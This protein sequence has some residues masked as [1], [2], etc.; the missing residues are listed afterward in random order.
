MRK[1]INLLISLFFLSI[2]N[3]GIAQTVT[4]SGDAESFTTE[5]RQYM[6]PN[7]NESETALLNKFISTWDSTM[8]D[9]SLKPM[10]MAGCI[11]M[12]NKRMRPDP[13]FIE[14]IGTIMD[15]IDYD[16]YMEDFKAWLEGLESLI[17]ENR[18]S[19][20]NIRSFINSATYLIR[21]NIIYHSSSVIW[22]TTS[23]RFSFNKEPSFTVS[24]PE[25]DIICYASRDSTIIHGT[26]GYF[27]PVKATWKGKGGTIDWSKAGYQPGE[28]YAE[29]GQYT[30]DLSSATFSIDSVLFHNS[31]YFKEPVYGKL[32]DRSTQI[33]EAG[34]ARFPKFE[35]YQKTFFLEDI[36]NEIDF[37]GG[38]T[39][40]G[41]IVKGTGERY[42][43]AIITMYKN[44]TLIA[45]ARSQDFLFSQDKIQTQ[46]T[47]FTLYL[48]ED[49]IY[50]SD[51]AFNF[52]VSDRE[53]N[54]YR[55]R[56]PTSRSP[57]F[58]SYHM[59]DM[60]FDYLSWK[61]DESYITLSRARGASRG[62]AYFESVSYFNE[63]EFIKMMGI[64]DYHPLYRLRAFA[65]YYY[66]KT[67]PVDE[68]ARWMNK[69]REYVIAMC[70]D[71][72]N[73]GF[74]FYDRA[75]NEV[76]IKQKLYD[77][78]DFYRK[79]LDY[80]VMSIFSETSSPVDNATLNMRN[81]KM[82]IKGVPRVFL[83]DSQNVRIFPYGREITLERN[84][85]FEFNGVV[86]AGMITVF[87]HNFKFS[88]DT[89]KINLAKVDSIM[90][91]VETGEVD[92][93]GRAL[94]R[95]VED[96]IQMTKADLLIDDPRNKSGLASLEQYPIFNAYSE[97][98]VFYDKIPNLEGVYPQ[99]D[100]YFRLIP[101]TFENTDRLS[102]SDLDLKGTFY[103]GKIIEPLDQTLTLQHDNSLGFFYKIPPEGLDVYKGQGTLYNSIE[104]S[105]RG[106]IGNGTLSYLTTTAES[107]KFRFFPDSMLAKTRKLTVTASTIFPEVISEETNI[108]WYPEKDEFSIEPLKDMEFNMFNN[109]TRL[110]GKLLMKKNGLRGDGV[111]NLTDSYLEANNYSF[112]PSSIY[113]D[114]ATYNLKSVSGDGFA[115]IADDAK[116]TIDFDKQM[117]VFSLNTDSSMVK[118]P[119]VQY[120]C[121]MT[122]FEYDMADKVLKMK[123]EGR[124]ASEL[125]SPEELLKQDRSNLEEPTFFSTNKINDTLTFSA[126]SGEYSLT[127]E[128]IIINNLNYI[129]VA[130]ALIQPDMGTL[131]I[132][133]G[134]KTD[135]IRNATIAINNT[136]LI[137][138]ASIDIINSK[139]Y[140]A[141]G[142]Y[143]YVDET[144]KIQNIKFDDIRV[145]SLRSKGS[146]NIPQIDNFMLSPEFTFQGD[147]SFTN[148]R[149]E[150]YF[151]G[152]TGIVQECDKI[153]SSPMRFESHIDPENIM[154]P[155]KEKPRDINGNLITVGSYIAVDS[156][157]IY[158]AFLS[159]SKSWADTPLVE[160]RGFI[161]YD[162]EDGKYKVAEKE[163]LANT[164]LPGS[165][166]SFDRNSC[167][168]YSEGPLNLGVDYGHL[169]IS[170]A[171]EV[172]HNTDS[173]IV[174]IDM[175]LSLDF[176]FSAPA[177]QVMADEIRYIPTLEPV[178]I[179][180][181]NYT[182]S[183][184][185][186]LGSEAAATLKEEMDLF[187]VSRSLPEGFEPEI[188]LN[189]LSLE[190]NQEFQ[191][192]RSTGKIGIGFVGTQAMNVY[193]D[194]YVELQKRRSG[195]LLDVYLK[196]DDA[197]WY[198]FSY[199][200]GVLMALSGNN[201]FNK[202]LVE[203]KVKD[204]RHPDHSIRSPYTYMVGVRT[205]MENFLRRM[206]NIEDD[207][208]GIVEEPI[209]YMP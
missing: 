89:F 71:L 148:D 72:T 108:K 129:P 56:F 15:F 200:R 202:I 57:Y 206:E 178:D 134:A 20:S 98:Y 68:L 23:N 76:T 62:Q 133:K 29:L 199:T 80:D 36:Y 9:N 103:G 147:V 171:G 39:F 104:M 167:E 73:K 48:E 11:S 189:D 140:T 7:L 47:A 164:S 84:R 41:A 182:K 169:D 59:M 180:G 1:L 166:I 2:C 96:L 58:D 81:Y 78:I 162:R 124:E 160:A 185:N 190:W 65:D 149:K 130:D 66:N 90:L 121:T 138:E 115:F 125:M 12:Q 93:S 111:L 46:S 42:S 123:Q 135:P 40:E 153:G 4:F 35:T 63:Q 127:D 201:S 54:T 146:G 14:F 26:S 107:E 128:K 181:N 157:H 102:P 83:S 191:S 27:D 34:K 198:W 156:T 142:I 52:N 161:I 195:D 136:H 79:K 118:F 112:S 100:Y 5:L 77:Y 192:Y 67:F 187:G 33:T 172:N 204:R 37:R 132:N 95:Q 194:G 105:N 152:S 154:I 197:T 18:S 144:E 175:I 158:S 188:V 45:K 109:G 120:I 16:I 137:H 116:T 126:S 101:F 179:S 150:L 10:I 38:L 113:A 173:G 196:A 87:G 208:A 183:M 32:I 92:E 141:G 155:V 193:V 25:S 22:K 170:G 88:Y 119:E 99:S 13:H 186:L 91:S 49:T 74:L 168:V 30:I 163:K 131:R 28:V 110:K 114:T 69:P 43:P 19:V 205:R 50:H 184:Q 44:D 177:L 122:D 207:D 75:N 17:N 53:L 6:G 151:L 165:L 176:H 31:T 139:R 60:Y 159:P 203:E 117:A 61:M 94:A 70:I 24:I 21:D 8:I 143:H 82:S 106:L 174:K 97:S 55:S 64:D 51:I 86:Q 85:S 145:D 3:T 209:D